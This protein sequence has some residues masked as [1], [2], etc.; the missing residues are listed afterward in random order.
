MR[1]ETQVLLYYRF[2]MKQIEVVTAV[3]LENNKYTCVQRGTNSKN[4]LS[5]KSEF[6]DGKI[7]NLIS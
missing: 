7:E 1:L 6:P 4:Y 3:I 2:N 5:E